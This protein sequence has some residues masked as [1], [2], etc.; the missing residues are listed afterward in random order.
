MTKKPTATIPEMI[1][2]Y[3]TY[4]SAGRTF[5]ERSPCDIRADR[6][7]CRMLDRCSKLENR[8]LA[9]RATT[10]SDLAAKRRFVECLSLDL[11]DMELVEIILKL[12]A[13]HLDR[14]A[15]R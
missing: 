14:A 9:T 15:A 8:I 11:H 7:M 12:D 10:P 3:R 6:M 2:E 4:E 1:S 5:A 13:A